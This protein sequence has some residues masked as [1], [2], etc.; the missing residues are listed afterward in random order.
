[1]SQYDTQGGALYI[2]YWPQALNLSRLSDCLIWLV[3]I[4]KPMW[5]GR[6]ISYRVLKHS[7]SSLQRRSC[8]G[9]TLNRWHQKSLQEGKESSSPKIVS[10]SAPSLTT[11]ISFCNSPRQAPESHYVLPDNS[12]VNLALFS[13]WNPEVH[14]SHLQGTPSNRQA[15]RLFLRFYKMHNFAVLLGVAPRHG[16]VRRWYSRPWQCNMATA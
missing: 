6:G 12:S 14:R 1:M 7:V 3:N 5:V 4:N 16:S 10:S 13:I 11:M 2:Y 9:G 8:Y 15:L